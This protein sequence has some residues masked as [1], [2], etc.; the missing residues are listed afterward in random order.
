MKGAVN[1][2]LSFGNEVFDI[3]LNRKVTFLKGDSGI[4]KTVFYN[5]AKMYYD[6]QLVNISKDIILELTGCEKLIFPA[7][8]GDSWRDKIIETDNCVVVVDESDAKVWKTPDLGRIIKKSG[9]YFL[10]IYRKN[11]WSSEFIKDVDEEDNGSVEHSISADI[12]LSC[13]NIGGIFINKS[14]NIYKDS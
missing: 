9:N 8:E 12:T 5:T 10:F 1:I 6:K 11:P 3:D 2:K 7:L 14:E 13:K 4:G